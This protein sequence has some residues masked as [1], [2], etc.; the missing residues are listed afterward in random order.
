M[1]EDPLDRI[2]EIFCGALELP[3]ADR[4]AYLD[5]ACGPDTKLREEVESLLSVTPYAESFLEQPA[6]APEDEETSGVTPDRIGPYRLIRQIASGGMG[7]VWLAER[8]D[9]HFEK[10]VAIKLIK[11]GMDTDE[12]LRRF[13][14]ERQLLAQL[15]HP[16]I[17]R[18]LDGGATPDERPYLVME[19]VDGFPLH[20]YCDAQ[21]LNLNQRLEL[22]LQVCDAV[23]YAHQN[24]VVHRDLKPSNILVTSDGTAKLLD[25]GIARLLSEGG[26]LDTVDVTLTGNRMLTPRYAS[27]EQIRGESLSTASDTYSLGVILYEL[28]TGTGPYRTES[29]SWAEYERAVCEQ[30]PHKP[31]SAIDHAWET[32]AAADTTRTVS[33]HT[34]GT[35][36]VRKLQRQLRGDLDNIVL[37][38]MRKE[39]ARRYASVEKLTDD[40]RRH[41]S[42]LPITARPDTWGYRTTKFVRRN[43]V[44]VGSVISIFVVLVA[45]ITFSSIS[46][47]RESRARETARHQQEA[48]EEVVSFLNQMLSS[49][50]PRVARGR[51]TAILRELLEDA[52]KRIESEFSNRPEVAGPIHRTL[53]GA[54]LAIGLYDEAAHHLREAE[55]DYRTTVGPESLEVA[56]CWSLQ[57]QVLTDLGRFEEA[58]R[59]HRLALETIEQHPDP[60]QG[61]AD[62]LNH[63]A[64]VLKYQARYDESETNYLECGELIKRDA[65]EDSLR[66]ALHLNNLGSLYRAKGRFEDAEIA[67]TRALEIREEKLPELHIDI[68]ISLQNLS[69]IHASRGRVQSALDLSKRAIELKR[70]L[71]EPD[72]PALADATQTYATSLQKAG[73]LDEAIEQYLAAIECYELAYPEGH[74]R[75][76]Q[77]NSNLAVAYARK[78]NLDES[79]KRQRRALEIRRQLHPD[80]DPSVAVSLHNLG[81]LL[82]DRKRYDEAEKLLEEGLELRRRVLPENHPYTLMT[83]H[84]LGVLRHKQGRLDLAESLC[85]EALEVRRKVLRQQH[86]RI[87][88][89]LFVLGHILI[90]A[91]RADEALPLLQESVSVYEA[92]QGADSPFTARARFML[93]RAFCGVRQHEQAEASLLSA[94]TTLNAKRGKSHPW[95]RETRRALVELYQEWEKPLEARKWSALE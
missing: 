47:I 90:D 69:N 24:L 54:Y 64:L 81:G 83:L 34:G 59:L 6:P 94:H 18:L 17:A 3:E 53:G 11:R 45:G 78:G 30:E 31:S 52:A 57:G 75:I 92:N 80:G 14:N 4:D 21:G 55:A 65:G 29:A 22:F 61:R 93:G 66:Y 5:R 56:D 8:A 48:A 38:A 12:I 10:A 87:G 58:E 50:N 1:T 32:R 23:H 86:P 40:I 43:R 71:L 95:T 28:L 20:E 85:R 51:D 84:T 67:Y 27:P 13:R 2:Q 33:P 35:T 36:Q 19:F 73:Q 72:H 15:E 49:V 16:N 42:G 9:A 68:T 91:E 62:C 7:T 82:L 74:S 44:L 37:K 60:D 41:Q 79:E 77:A 46:Y 76:A 88:L 26:T 25:F 70:Q 89:N 63:I 39:P